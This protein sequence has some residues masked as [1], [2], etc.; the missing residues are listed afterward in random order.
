MKEK[1]GYLI[2][3]EYHLLL[4]IND[5]LKKYS[6]TSLYDVQLILIRSKNG[7]RLKQELDLSFLPFNVKVID[8]NIDFNGKL[9]LEEKKELDAL[10]DIKFS[11]Y[12]FFQ[13]HDVIDIILVDKFVSIGAEINLFQDGLKPYIINTLKRPIGLIKVVIKQNIW[14]RRNGYPVNDYFSFLRCTKYSFTKGISKVFLTFPDAY[15]NWN[16]KAVEKIEIDTSKEFWDIIKKVFKW[17]DELLKTKENVIFFMS[18]PMHDDGSFEM[19]VLKKLLK[20]HPKSQLYIKYHPLTSAI[21]IEQYKKLDN[22]T[23]IDSQIPAEIFIQELSNSIVL[24][25]CSTSMFIDN[26]KSKFYWFSE[27][28]EGNNIKLIKRYD[29]VN[30]TKHVHIVHSVDEIIF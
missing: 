25:V 4:S 20:K 21:K 3:T 6:D 30:P 12:N 27:I 10:L 19:G 2:H 9:D 24:S 13:E 15:Y 23:I 7:T 18:Q 5:A 14:I 11:V 1:I 28:L 16:N 26:Q 29:F 22:V 17:D 8:F